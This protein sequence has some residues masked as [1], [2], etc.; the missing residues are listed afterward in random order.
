ML[1][2]AN[3]RPPPLVAGVENGRRAASAWGGGNRSGGGK[4]AKG[5]A[6]RTKWAVA[7]RS[8]VTRDVAARAAEE[9]A[10]KLVEQ[11]ELRLSA[12]LHHAVQRLVDAR[13]TRAEADAA[14]ALA[15]GAVA[16]Q[17]ARE[18]EQR[19]GRLDGRLQTLESWVEHTVPLLRARFGKEHQRFPAD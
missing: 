5:A 14:D 2:A 6:V 18:G 7:A 1:A 15:R 3:A 17:R 16:L 4:A 9:T 8:A 19:A 13:V 12:K 11:L 10:K